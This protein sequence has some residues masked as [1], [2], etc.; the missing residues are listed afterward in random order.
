MKALVYYGPKEYRLEDKPIPSIK[1]GEVLLKVVAA[2]ICGT[3]LKIFEHGHHAV[4][5][6]VT[7][8]HE[9]VGTIVQSKSSNTNLRNGLNVLV[10]TP[11]GCMNC[12]YCLAGK[13]NMCPL[14]ADRGHSIGYYTDG[15][16]AEYLRIPK[17]A[18]DQ[19]VLIVI[20]KKIAVPLT[21][22]PIC[23]PLSCVINGQEK[24]KISQSD[25]VLI[26][27]AGPI[28]CMQVSLAKARKA[29]KIILADIDVKK[30]NLAK[31]AGV[32]ADLFVNSSKTDLK[33]RVLK[34]SGGIGADVIII[35]APSG[36]GQEDAVDMAAPLG[37][38]SFF[39]GLPKTMPTITLNSNKLHYRELE[40][41]GA[42]ASTRRQYEEAL[43]LVTTK[44]IDTSKL[45][46]HIFPLYKVQ[47][48][49]D[50]MKRGEAIKIILTP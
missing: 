45:V 16:F 41:Y 33:T 32:P 21:H 27:G 28:G 19:G 14:V 50:C 26:M 2:G 11:V 43:R 4:K 46:T 13:Q 6:G 18:V 20:P 22:I 35:A 10:V 48:A 42:Y 5:V 36:K 30:L 9:I 23:E 8:G 1:K 34:E 17:D 3:D 12:K 15:G 24:L 7:T 44:E 39:G 40:I 38:I 25:V 49:I 31:K 29:R 47:D 37:R